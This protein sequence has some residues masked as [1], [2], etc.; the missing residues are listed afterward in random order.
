M[1]EEQTHENAARATWHDM[2]VSAGKAGDVTHI[3]SGFR[4]DAAAREE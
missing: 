3:D 2:T 4:V 1:P